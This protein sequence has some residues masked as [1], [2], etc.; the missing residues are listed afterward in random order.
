L[1]EEQRSSS[2]TKE[3][4]ISHIKVEIGKKPS[5]PFRASHRVKM[6]KIYPYKMDVKKL[7]EAA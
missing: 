2:I 6:V 1:E 4:P 7:P 3:V 5:C